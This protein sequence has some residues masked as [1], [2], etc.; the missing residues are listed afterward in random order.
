MNMKRIFKNVVK[1]LLPNRIK[2]FIK[3]YLVQTVRQ[4]SN[5]Q[6][7]PIHQKL[8]LLDRLEFKLE[9]LE[10]RIIRVEEVLLTLEALEEKLLLH[11]SSMGVKSAS[12]NSASVLSDDEY[13]SLEKNICSGRILKEDDYYSA[14]ATE[15][16]KNASVLDLGC[17]QGKC[18][19]T[20]ND[21]GFIA[22][23]IDANTVYSNVPD[24]I[25]GQLPEILTNWQSNSIDIVVSF[26]LIEHLDLK[27]YRELI[28]EAFRILKK[29]GKVFLETPNTQSLVTMSHYYYKDP[30]HLMPRHPEVYTNILRLCGFKNTVIKNLPEL[31]DHVFEGIAP[32]E[33]V[34]EELLQQVNKKFLDIEN[35]LF[36]CSGNVLIIGEK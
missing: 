24:V 26:H 17:G 6:I 34:E 18:I 9:I 20:L 28:S 5:E 13:E 16:P 31:D 15:F 8:V 14:L 21:K 2:Y 11:Q 29:G 1:A 4:I 32:I 19:Q 35:I 7:A 36:S 23:G 27:K 12:A 22:K 25:I 10:K 3:K 33:S 30:T